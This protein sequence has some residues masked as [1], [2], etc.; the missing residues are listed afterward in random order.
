MDRFG[1]SPRIVTAG[2]GE[3]FMLPGLFWFATQGW[4]DRKPSAVSL[5]AVYRTGTQ[6]E[7]MRTHAEK[8]D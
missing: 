4:W 2:I 7:K 5:D 6:T 8:S 3:F 1:F